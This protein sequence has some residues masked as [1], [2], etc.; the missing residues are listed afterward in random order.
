MFFQADGAARSEASGEA[1]GEAREGNAEEDV[2]KL[3]KCHSKDRKSFA[4]PPSYAPKMFQ[5]PNEEMFGSQKLTPKTVSDSVF[6]IKR[7]VLL[8]CQLRLSRLA[9]SCGP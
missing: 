6:D 8:S 7:V 5:I 2:D 1:R 9:Y 4:I 3:E